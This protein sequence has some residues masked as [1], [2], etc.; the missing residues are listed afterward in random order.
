VVLCDAMLPAAG[1][2]TMLIKLDLRDALSQINF[3]NG[4]IEDGKIEI[5]GNDLVEFRTRLKRA[6][7]VED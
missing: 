3:A 5:K 4:E 1:M 6:F 7:K 2:A